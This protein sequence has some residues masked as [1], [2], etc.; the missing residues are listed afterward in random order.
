MISSGAV[1]IPILQ[2]RSLS[3]ALL[4]SRPAYTGDLSSSD[5]GL[6]HCCGKK[7]YGV[8]EV[9][10]RQRMTRSSK[11]AK[12]WKHRAPAARNSC[13]FERCEAPADERFWGVEAASARFSERCQRPT[14]Q[15]QRLNEEGASRASDIGVYSWYDSWLDPITRRGGSGRPSFWP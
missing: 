1:S 10:A 6:T 14:L 15:P 4:R 7:G 8:D 11:H 5:S 12:K 9:F 2:Q 13:S 3:L